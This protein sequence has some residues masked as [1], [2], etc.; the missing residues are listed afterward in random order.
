M[1]T[2]LPFERQAE[3][4]EQLD[5]DTRQTV[6]QNLSGI[7]PPGGGETVSSIPMSTAKLEQIWSSLWQEW[8]RIVAEAADEEGPYITQEAHWEPPYFDNSAFVDDLERVAK[9]MRPL[10]QSAVQYQFSPE[11]GFA[12]ALANAEDEVSTA[13]PEWIEIEGFDLE[14]NLTFCLL[15]WEWLQFDHEEK[16]A[17]E[18]VQYIREL[19]ESFSTISL[20]SN[21]FLDFLTQLPE[22]DQE[23][24][25]RG[26]TQHRESSSW[27]TRLDNIYSP[28]YAFYMYC[29]EQYSPEKFLDNLKAT[30]PQ[31]W[32]NG[33]PVIEDLLAKKDYPASLKII[34]ETVSALLKSEHVREAWSPETALL[35]AV[36]NRYYGASS[37]LSDHKI[38][39]DYWQQTAKNVGQ[40]GLVPILS[41][42]LLALDH[43]FDWKTMFKAFEKAPIPQQTRQALFASWRDYIIQ[44]AKP[45]IWEAFGR[46]ERH[47]SPWWLH[48]L[49]ES[50][51]DPQKGPAWFQKQVSQWLSRPPE[52]RHTLSEGFQVLRLLIADLG[53]INPQNKKQYPKFF[54]TVIR[55]GELSS[56]DQSSRRA[57][58]KQSAQDNLQALVMAYW[59]AHLHHFMPDPGN[60]SKSDYTQHAQWMAALRELNPA[61]YETLLNH[62]RRDHHRRRNL[63]QAMARLGLD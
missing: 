23:V 18:F 6:Q 13:M 46:T 11:V 30:I 34:E 15:E 42:Q 3:V 54:E 5:P 24:I 14:E 57:Y 28:W 10:L 31:Q 56:P 43:F 59:K 17:F 8:D 63:W 47:D 21:A 58:L 41:L 35:F 2:I 55:P 52:G 1:F 36:V 53:E 33:L 29:L 61:S 37:G 45:Q 7:V 26:L 60:A 51:A 19:E 48:W 27:K 12:E 16:D 39:L 20:E 9:S 49:I 44:R 38:L 40:A 50:I 32:Q 4:L 62:W 25:F 22:R